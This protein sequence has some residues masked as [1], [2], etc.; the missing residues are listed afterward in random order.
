M[1]LT[2]RIPGDIA[3][4]MGVSARWV[5]GCLEGRTDDDYR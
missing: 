4:S 5:G 2:V 3:R 1:E